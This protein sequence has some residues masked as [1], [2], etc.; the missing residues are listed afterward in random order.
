MSYD[1]RQRAALQDEMMHFQRVMQAR[2]KGWK[3]KARQRLVRRPDGTLLPLFDVFLCDVT[4][5]GTD[6][7]LGEP[8]LVDGPFL[9]PEEA[10]AVALDHEVGKKTFYFG[11]RAPRLNLTP[12]RSDTVE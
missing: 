11:P 3:Y 5:R 9:T 2:K 12:P 6:S 4:R 8:V 7:S 10:E 1:P